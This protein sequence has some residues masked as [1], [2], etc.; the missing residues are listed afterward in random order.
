MP[1]TI[2]NILII[3]CS[4]KPYFVDVVIPYFTDIKTED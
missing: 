1:S 2:L 3:G 4:Q